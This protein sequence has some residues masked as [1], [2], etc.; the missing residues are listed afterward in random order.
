MSSYAEVIVL[1][2]G[3]TEQRFVKQLL[4]PYMAERGVYLTAIHSG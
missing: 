1:V 2:E 4:S 3:P